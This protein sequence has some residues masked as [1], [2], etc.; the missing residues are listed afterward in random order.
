MRFILNFRI[1]MI[2]QHTHCTLVE[3]QANFENYYV[4]YRTRGFA[5]KA[6]IGKVMSEAIKT[7]ELDLPVQTGITTMSSSGI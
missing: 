6:S 1:G 2:V 7:C 5:M 4:W 3:E